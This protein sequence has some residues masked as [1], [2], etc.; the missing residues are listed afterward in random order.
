LLK[1]TVPTLKDWQGYNIVHA[2]AFY[3]RLNKQKITM[4]DI[5]WMNKKLLN[6]EEQIKELGLNYEKLRQRAG[7]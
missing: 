6:Y 3:K 7:I 2:W 5:N 1:L 4:E